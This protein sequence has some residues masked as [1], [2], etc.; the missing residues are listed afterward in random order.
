VVDI[1]FSSGRI[2]HSLNH[3]ISWSVNDATYNETSETPIT[4]D[5]DAIVNFLPTA[6]ALPGVRDFLMDMEA[7]DYEDY[8]QNYVWN[9]EPFQTSIFFDTMRVVFRAKE[10]QF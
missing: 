7:A 8:I 5:F 6:A 9:S 4:V 10:G 3:V 2:I 1:R